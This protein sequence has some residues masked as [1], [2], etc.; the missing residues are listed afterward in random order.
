MTRAE[1]LEIGILS[2]KG[3]SYRKIGKQLDRS[4]NTISYEVRKNSV[5]GTYDPLKAD[6]VAHLRKRMRKLQWSKIEQ[7]PLVKTFVLEKLKARWNPDE[8][9]GFLKRTKDKRYV[10]KTAIY[11]WLRTSR[12]ERYCVYLYSKRKRV[13][14]RK[15]K[16]K[17]TLIPNRIGIERRNDGVNNRTLYGHWERDSVVSKK[18][19]HGGMATHQE[20]KSRFL[21]AQKVET[22]RPDE[23]ANATRAVADALVMRSTTTDNDIENRAI[24]SGAKQSRICAQTLDCFGQRSRKDGL[25]IIVENYLVMVLHLYTEHHCV[26]P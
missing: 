4:P 25:S 23:H 5:N 20:R 1:R 26:R 21:S 22:M 8:I 3:Y 17:K 18:G 10:S 24:T 12:G 14:K 7:F 19:C 13:K 9:A 6:A 15:P 16:T 11:E 2:D